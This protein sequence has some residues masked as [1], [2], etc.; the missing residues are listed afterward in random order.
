MSDPAYRG[1]GEA[2]RARVTA[3]E[4][5]LRK[6]KSLTAKLAA[7][8]APHDA[9]KKKIREQVATI[10][11][12]RI[13]AMLGTLFMLA[14]F[15]L[16]MRAM[17]SSDFGVAVVFVGFAFLLAWLRVAWKLR[18]RS[19]EEREGERRL[20]EITK[21]DEHD[22]RRFRVASSQLR[23]QA[24]LEDVDLEALERELEEARALADENWHREKVD[25]EKA[26]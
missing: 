14:A 25:R 23:E 16:L 21:Q 8:S 11:K 20:Q 18:F 4:A 5:E 7:L 12:I 2:A 1:A 19:S 17:S 9:E 10:K 15:P 13:G 24:H 22:E 6:R 26:D 3:L